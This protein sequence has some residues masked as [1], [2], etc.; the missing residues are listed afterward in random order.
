MS[1][2]YACTVRGGG[3]VD[4]ENNNNPS[5]LLHEDN[6]IFRIT[7]TPPDRWQGLELSPSIQYS[8]HHNLPNSHQILL[9]KTPRQFHSHHHELIPR[10]NPPFFAHILKNLCTSTW[11]KNPA[12]ESPQFFNQ[13]CPTHSLDI[14]YFNT[15]ISSV[16]QSSWK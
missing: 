1:V 11:L 13:F 3:G 14:I 16:S 5:P 9:A 10:K 12:S 6:Y 8:S 2:F 4:Y 7:T 15:G